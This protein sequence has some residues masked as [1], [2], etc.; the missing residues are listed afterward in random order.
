MPTAVERFRERMGPD[1]G[2]EKWALGKRARTSLGN[3]LVSDPKM[4]NRRSGEGMSQKERAPFLVKRQT[5][6]GEGRRASMKASNAGQIWRSTCF[7]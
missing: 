2:M 3:P 7:Q 5:S 6:F 1:M 4:R